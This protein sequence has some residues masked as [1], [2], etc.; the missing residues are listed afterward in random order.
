MTQYAPRTIEE[1]T[2]G[3]IQKSM[4]DLLSFMDKVTPRYM[5]YDQIFRAS[6]ISR[7]KKQNFAGKIGR[8]RG[9]FAGEKSEFAEKSANFADFSRKKSKFRRVFRGKFLENSTDFMGN[10]GGGG[11]TSPRNNQ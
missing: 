5:Y 11:E 4:V 10:F 3:E 7:K 6:D 1:K 9:I 8:F 2:K